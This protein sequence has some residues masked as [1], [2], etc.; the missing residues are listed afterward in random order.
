MHL[1]FTIININYKLFII[2]TEKTF[3]KSIN[4]K[5]ENRNS[6]ILFKLTSDVHCKIFD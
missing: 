6:T 2:K 4:I 3:L 5:I 1:H